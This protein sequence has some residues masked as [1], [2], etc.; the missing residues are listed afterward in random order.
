MKE[1]VGEV[2]RNLRFVAG[3][4]L[5]ALAFMS[6]SS[7][8]VRL[9]ALLLGLSELVTATTRVCP[10]NSFIGIDTNRT[11]MSDMEALAQ[12]TTESPME[13]RA[14]AGSA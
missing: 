1:N 2:D 9:G 4:A 14:L 10:L 7:G 6:R 11:D 8:P 3:G 12:T 5:L 13:D